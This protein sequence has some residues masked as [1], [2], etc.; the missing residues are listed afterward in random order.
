M[1]YDSSRFFHRILCPQDGAAQG[2]ACHTG[3]Q[4]GGDVVQGDATDGDNGQVDA[5]RLHLLY[6]GTV[7]FEAEDGAELLFW[8]W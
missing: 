7:S 8:W 6:D 1:T 3:L 4:D 2:D 5:F